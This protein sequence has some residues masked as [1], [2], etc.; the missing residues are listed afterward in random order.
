M[1]ACVFAGQGSQYVGMGSQL[2]AKNEAARRVYAEAEA[3]LGLDLTTLDEALLAQTRY[4]Q[5]AIV[6][7]SLAAHAALKAEGVLA[8]DVAFAGFS[9]GE[10]SALAASGVLS[11]QDVL[12]LVE[13]RSRLMQ[14]A[15]EQNPGSMYAVLGLEDAAVEAV[16]NQPSFKNEVFPVNY[17]CP[18]Q[19][20]I[21]GSVEAS[22]AA[23]D[24]L[25]AAGAKRAMKLNVNGA[26]HTRLMGSAAPGLSAFASQLNFKQ[27]SGLL[28]SN[29]TGK[30]VPAEV[31]WPA[32]LGDHLCHAV[33]WTDEV[34][35][36]EAAGVTTFIE[37]GPG[38][39][40]SGLIKKISGTAIIA[41]I[42]DPDSLAAVLAVLKG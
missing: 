19:L 27:P 32:Y 40:L 3:L 21:A 14:E 35:A 15:A 31:N 39:V 16:L 9:L 34:R 30:S 17:N 11:V 6:T 42:E 25:K 8:Q 41:N 29:L 20:V 2:A 18:G 5:L 24:A 28:F 33:R 38:K 23:A 12:R 37:M 10:Y 1:I 13:E 22:A 7:L 4:A 36:L 26:F